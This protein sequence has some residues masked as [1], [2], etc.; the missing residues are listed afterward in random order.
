M[1]GGSQGLVNSTEAL[2][3][4]DNRE[5][6]QVGD[7]FVR[8]EGGADSPR[9]GEAVLGPEPDGLGRFDGTT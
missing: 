5:G 3:G 9:P 2:P 1:F 7:A 6:H 4:A 8:D